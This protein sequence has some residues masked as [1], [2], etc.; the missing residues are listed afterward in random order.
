MIKNIAKLTIIA[1]GMVLV[2]TTAQAG[3]FG[4]GMTD[5]GQRTAMS[6]QIAPTQV[7]SFVQ[8]Q[9]PNGWNAV[10]VNYSDG[11]FFQNGNRWVERNPRGTYYFTETHRD[12][13]SVYLFDSG[14]NA[15]IQLDLWQKTIYYSDSNTARTPIYSITGASSGGPVIRY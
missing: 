11:Q 15:R 5:T 7:L 1:T 3:A 6:S 9:A 13:W 4:I 12:E 2:A 10:Q 8:D 14:R